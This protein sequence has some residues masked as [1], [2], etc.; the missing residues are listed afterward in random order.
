MHAAWN[1]SSCLWQPSNS[2]RSWSAIYME[3]EVET[4]DGALLAHTIPN[5]TIYVDIYYILI[6]FHITSG[7]FLSWLSLT[8]IYD[9]VIIVSEAYLLQHGNLRHI[10]HATPWSTCL[11]LFLSYLSLAFKVR[12][13]FISTMKYWLWVCRPSASKSICHHWSQTTGCNCSRHSRHL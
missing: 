6:E 12:H 4:W 1:S 10:G 8:D 3:K 5:A 13:H 11:M 9:I 7:M 2:V